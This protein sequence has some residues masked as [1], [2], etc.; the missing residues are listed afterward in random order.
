MTL[1]DDEGYIWVA[2]TNGVCR[3]DGYTFEVFTTKD[4]LTDN[5]IYELF[6]DPKGRIWFVSSQLTLSYWQNNKIHTYKYNELI[7]KQYNIIINIENR[8]FYVD[9]YDNIYF[10]ISKNG[11]YRIDS[12]GQVFKFK[13]INKDLSHTYLM[14]IDKA[15]YVTYYYKGLPDTIYYDWGNAVLN[16]KP[17]KFEETSYF[18]KYLLLTSDSKL[19]FSFGKRIF[20]I[21]GKE[22]NAF[23]EPDYIISLNE[24]KSKNTW[25]GLRENGALCFK[26]G[27]LSKKP[28]LHILKGYPVSDIFSDKEGGLWFSTLTNGL[29]YTPS[30]DVLTLNKDDG[31]LE[32]K[33][34][35][36]S[37]VDTSKIAIFF[38]SQS[39][40]LLGKT[41]EVVKENIPEGEYLRTVIK[42]TGRE[43][44]VT[45]K[46]LFLKRNGEWRTVY[47]CFKDETNIISGIF[48]ICNICEN[49]KK[50][51]LIL[52]RIYI[53]IIK[54]NKIKTLHANYKGIRFYKY[55]Y[56]GESKFYFASNQG[57][58]YLIKD[59]SYFY[60]DNNPELNIDSL[61]LYGDDY[62]ELKTRMNDILFNPVDSGLWMASKEHGIYLL[63][64]NVVYNIDVE[65]G[66][67]SNQVYHLTLQKNK[68]WASTQNGISR[69]VLKP[70]S[71]S[72]EGIYNITTKHGLASN[73]VSMTLIKGDT[74]YAATDKGLSFFSTDINISDHIGKVKITEIKINEKDTAINNFYELPYNTS[75]ITLTYKY[76]SYLNAGKHVYQYRLA[77]LSDDWQTTTNTEI[78]FTTLP[79]G[80][81]SFEVRVIF[82]NKTTSLSSD[83]IHFTITPPFWLTWR[84]LLSSVV[85]V[86]A[87]GFGVY[88][89]RIK[90]IVKQNELKYKLFEYQRKALSSQM[91]PHFIFNSL[92]SIQ[93][94]ILKND[95]VTS[96]KYL[97]KFALL[98]RNILN[99][100]EYEFISLESEIQTLITYIE[101][102]QLRFGRKFDFKIKI[103]KSLDICEI[104]IPSMLIQPFAENAIWHG[105]MNKESEDELGILEIEIAPYDKFIK[106]I[107]TDNGVGREKAS[108]I[109]ARSNK[110]QQSLGAKITEQRLLLLNKVYKDKL[111]IVFTDLF[112]ENKKA[113]G[114]KVELYIPIII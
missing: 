80:D 106:C 35:Q 79:P 77:G 57:A 73:N 3:F 60:G 104:R 88:K 74:L 19:L 7:K 12:K 71:E 67:A 94:F 108:Q 11:V 75:T 54:N 59:G 93:L 40:N 49:R 64:N 21:F 99:N 101:L 34:T 37:L 45:N 69:I 95:P 100:S 87:I 26:Y 78:R 25:V 31:L 58:G 43:W 4:G 18:N 24:D 42:T 56:D 32:D 15:H 52:E 47:N 105:L 89:Y 2:T 33:I 29:Y 62:P 86:I 84:F 16:F 96:N 72:I 38:R 28:F 5:V 23:E 68:L 63:K 1:Q 41:I 110:T 91:N 27:D 92:N 114:T 13:N 51:V 111:S 109:K 36:I 76:L 81:Y 50:E 53:Y 17:K 83:T 30:L 70:N 22:V 65:D 66:L 8:N 85:F 14:Q 97:S 90:S 10:S 113:I 46:S 44:L 55:L 112:D 20:Q 103:D 82:E 107:I 39:Y 61:Y 9:K 98:M 48:N 102:E 6:K